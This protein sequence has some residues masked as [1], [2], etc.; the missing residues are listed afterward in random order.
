MPRR[1][2][3]RIPWSTGNASTRSGSPRRS[4]SAATQRTGRRRQVDHHPRQLP[5]GRP[6][7][8][9]LGQHAHGQGRE[10]QPL[11]DPQPTVEDV[12]AQ[13]PPVQGVC[14]R[15]DRQAEERRRPG[16]SAGPRPVAGPALAR[17]TSTST[18]AVASADQ[19]RPD[20]TPKRS[21]EAVEPTSSPRCHRLSGQARAT[22]G[23]RVERHGRQHSLHA[24][25][26][27]VPGGDEQSGRPHPSRRPRPPASAT[28]RTTAGATREARQP[29]REDDGQNP[30]CGVVP[31]GQH[32]DDPRGSDQDPA[33]R[34]GRGASRAATARQP[35]TRRPDPPGRRTRRAPSAAKEKPGPREATT[36]ATAVALPVRSTSTRATPGA[37]GNRAG[38]HGSGCRT[39]RLPRTGLARM[40]TTGTTRLTLMCARPVVPSVTGIT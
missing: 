18:T 17:T 25:R 34:S 27:G 10:R 32:P 28:C 36:T 21:S 22:R 16:A 19:A 24:E 33:E 7:P 8:R 31:L 38:P 40:L 30:A 9:Q 15:R 39:G 35:G 20:P 1:R 37:S 13:E 5:L 11:G 2:R 26:D 12:G 29:Q 6:L 14:V 23:R 4:A 3:S